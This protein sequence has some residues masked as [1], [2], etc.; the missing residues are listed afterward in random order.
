MIL[1]RALVT[2]ILL[3]APV[4]RADSGVLIP[5]DKQQPDPAILSLQEMSV[6]ITIDNGDA[7]VFI[8]QIF[9]NH[10]DKVEEGSYVFALPVS[11]RLTDRRTVKKWE[12]RLDPVVEMERCVL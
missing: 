3:A 12:Y 7:R 10:T 2:S 11:D 6:S 4:A 9:A 8:T 1:I 5:R